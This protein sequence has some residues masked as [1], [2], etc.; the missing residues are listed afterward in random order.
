M[1]NSV[2]EGLSYLNNINNIIAIYE[3]LFDDKEIVYDFGVKFFN[4]YFKEE[5]DCEDSTNNCDNEIKKCLQKH[6]FGYF[7][8]IKKEYHSV[9]INVIINGKAYEVN[10]TRFADRCIL[11]TFFR[12][13]N[14]LI[15]D[16]IFLKGKDII[17]NTL[18]I[19]LIVNKNGRILYGNKKAIETYGY[20]FDEL[21]NLDIFT[22]RNED[23]TE[24]TQKQLNEAL[25]RGIKFKTY[26]YKKDGSNFPV[27]VRSIYSNKKSKDMVISI[28]RDISDIEQVYK[29]GRIFSISFDIIDDPC[30]IFDK[31]M[32]IFQWSKGAERKFGF[33]KEEIQGKNINQLVPVDKL[34]E[35][36]KLV[37]KLIQG[38]IIKN[39]GTVRLT[40]D[41][42]IVELLISASPIY[43]ENVSFSGI[44]A[45]YKDITDKK[46]IENKIREKYEQIEMLSKG[47]N[48]KKLNVENDR[49]IDDKIHQ[50]KVILYVEDN[51][52]SQEVMESI[53]KRKGYKYIGAYNGND[54]LHILKSNKVDLILM[55]IQMPELD[56]FETTKI[57][58][59]QE[60]SGKHIPIIALTAYTMNEDKEK[61]M[62]ADMDDYLIKPFEVEKLYEIIELNL[63]K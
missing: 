14:I 40:K 31:D 63:K 17:E 24:F 4:N 22:L 16:Q 37:D 27:E 19:I 45:I 34:E 59:N 30:I 36:S 6:L 60:V 26:H 8:K 48:L 57:I 18:D 61:C 56:G 39:Y 12:N 62:D 3:P 35:S 44:A 43:D 20:S 21:I 42:T 7:A 13:N 33:K 41:G 11:C 9:N 49:M 53:I 51:L 23:T 32:N 54:A 46:M 2:F 47:Q 38:K 29:D 28:I 1:I 25:D 10:L 15:N 52:I 5:F 55:D 58:R 50:N